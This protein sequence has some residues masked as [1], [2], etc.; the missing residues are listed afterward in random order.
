MRSATLIMFFTSVLGL[1]SLNNALAENLFG[2][3]ENS[4]DQH[5]KFAPR[6]DFDTDGCLPAAIIDADGNINEGLPVSGG[7]TEGCRDTSQLD[8]ANTLARSACKTINDEKYCAIMY[9]LYFEKDVWL[10]FG[11]LKDGH[12]HD[13]EVVV[14]YTQNDTFQYGAVSAHGDLTVRFKDDI[15]FDD[16][17]GNWGGSNVDHMRVVY[18]KDGITTHSFRFSQNGDGVAENPKREWLT[19]KLVSWTNLPNDFKNSLSNYDFGGANFEMKNDRW[20][21]V[22]I[23]KY[24]T[25]GWPAF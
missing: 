21:S 3:P 1:S 6:F 5:S 13:I 17:G 25:S 16:N 10:D 12:R 9:L 24:R 7:L 11:F 8:R 19:P 23:N 20:K 15:Q 14:V 22:Y 18:H 2:L 4:I